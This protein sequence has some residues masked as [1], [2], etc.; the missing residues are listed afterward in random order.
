METFSALSIC[1]GTQRPVTR[2]FDVYFDLPLNKRLRKQWWG[3]WFI[4]PGQNGH[5][6]ADDIFRGIF[7]NE[8]Y[9]LL[10]KISLN[11]QLPS[12]GFD[13]GFAPKRLKTGESAVFL[14]FACLYPH[15]DK[16]FYTWYHVLERCCTF[17]HIVYRAWKK[18]MTNLPF[19]P[20]TLCGLLAS[21]D[22]LK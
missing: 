11:W 14:F 8:K 12:I 3:W 19:S 9:W 15:G 18:D 2:S 21:Y 5:R 7:L 4:S 16:Q 1:A 10:I 22:E 6:L 20:L 17:K 13:N